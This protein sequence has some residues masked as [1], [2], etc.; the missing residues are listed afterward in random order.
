MVFDIKRIIEFSFQHQRAD[1]VAVANQRE[2]QP[3]G[4]I[5]FG[6]IELAVVK[7]GKLLDLCGAE[8]V[9]CD[10]LRHLH[11]YRRLWCFIFKCCPYRRRRFQEWVSG[12]FA[13]NRAYSVGASYS[14]GP[15]HVAAGYLHLNNNA[16]S[17]AAA[18][19][20]TNG[21]VTDSNPLVAARQQTWG[22]G[23]NYAFGPAVVGFVYSQTNLTQVFQTGFSSHFQ[24]F[25]GNLRY[26]LTPAL[27]VAGAYTYSR[28]GGNAGS[29][30]PHWNQ[31]GLQTDYNLSKRTDVYLQSVYQSVSTSK[32]NAL[33]VA[34][35]NGV[36][37]P[38]STTNQVEVTAGLRHRF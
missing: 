20:N 14:W 8:V 26:N 7:L 34:F 37:A 2:Q 4:V 21:A 35:I 32:N 5:K 30:S 10:G 3:V 18:N 11:G 36:S 13:D 25:E 33:G 38:S 16:T 29:G 23:V 1:L 28:A 17:Q 27:N 9:T 6:P 15:L 12:G 19:F 24:N 31:V 22:A